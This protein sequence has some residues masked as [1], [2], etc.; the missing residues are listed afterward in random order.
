M[1]N[2]Y[3]Y[4][5]ASR[6][7][8]DIYLNNAAT[9]WP[10]PDSVI[11]AVEQYLLQPPGE[12]GR[13]TDAL[14]EDPVSNARETVS[15]FFS[16]PDQDHVVFTSGAT[17]SLNMLIHGFSAL[18]PDPFHVITTDLDHNSVLRP[19]TTLA[20]RNQVQL[21]VIPSRNGHVSAGDIRD[22]IRDDTLLAVISHGSNVMGT[23]QKIR[24]IRSALGDEIFVIADGAQAAGQVPVN[25]PALGVDA[26]V[27]TG[28]KYLFGM[29]GTG[30][31]WIRNPEEVRPVFQGGTG[32]DSANLRQPSQLPE[33]FE[34]GT[35]NY[36]GIIS[37]TAGIS[38]I[39]ETGFDAIVSHAQQCIDTFYEP[40][41]ES[42]DIVCYSPS[43]DLPVF[44]VNIRGIE[45]DMAGFIL[46][47]SYGIIT[48]TG[49]HCSP[50]IHDA[51]TG[52]EGC[53]RISP[54]LLTDPGECRYAGEIL[55]ALAK[56][57]NMSG[58]NL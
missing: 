25:I 30:G 54:S 29:P 17:E 11:R 56:K 15:R 4:M 20:D 55:C 13:S 10:K 39:Q 42:E 43:P 38:F 44:P 14:S 24:E 33:R 31:F 47:T 40:I 58:Q 2:Y 50:L 41:L 5:N 27:F 1:E 53:I 12:S 45:P 21:S 19:L 8:R 52:G 35:P 3:Y 34:S 16:C 48:R 23:V 22:T 37:L 7:S 51:I 6:P 32:T 28:H 57:V 46:R 9:S 49:L 18:H 26:Y 36:P